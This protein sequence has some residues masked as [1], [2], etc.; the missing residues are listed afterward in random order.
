MHLF[1]SI[2]TYMVGRQLQI[3]PFFY[4][5]KQSSHHPHH[6][7]SSSIDWSFH[8]ARAPTHFIRLPWQHK[9]ARRNSSAHLP[10]VPFRLGL[11]RAPSSS[12]PP[13]VTYKKI[14]ITISYLSRKI[15]FP[16]DDHEEDD[17][18]YYDDLQLSYHNIL[19]CLYLH[20][21]NVAASPRPFSEETRAE[22]ILTPSLPADFHLFFLFKH[23]ET[24]KTNNISL[25]F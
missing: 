14:I 20:G 4:K 8:P 6:L 12:T 10:S 19:I 18:D 21:P 16:D 11:P 9:I 25:F 17:D 2:I 3:D 5:N 15:L 24:T 1:R 22:R 23:L 7:E 13:K